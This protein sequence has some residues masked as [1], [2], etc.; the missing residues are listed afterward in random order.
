MMNNLL[1][2]GVEKL[3]SRRSSQPDPR[4]LGMDEVIPVP[5]DQQLLDQ[6]EAR[7]NGIVARQ[8]EG[9]VLLSVARL[10]AR[11]SAC[12]MRRTRIAPRRVNREPRIGRVEIQ[13]TN[14]HD[15]L[16]LR[17]CRGG[18]K[19]IGPGF[20][21][22]C[23][24]GNKPV[25]ICRAAFGAALKAINEGDDAAAVS[26]LRSADS[27][28]RRAIYDINDAALQYYL[29]E[30]E[31]FRNLYPINWANIVPAYGEI[32][33]VV[34]A[35]RSS[36]DT[37]TRTVEKREEAYDQIRP[38]ALALK[39]AYE[40]LQAHQTDAAQALANRN[41]QVLESQRLAAEAKRVSRRFWINMAVL[42]A[43]AACSTTS[44]ILFL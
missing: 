20:W 18:P 25:P 2:K 42:V 6:R 16:A 23:H 15:L 32:M 29:A 1:A 36:I 5:T 44:L 28:A 7:M 39:E 35:A 12:S 9:S 19:D 40:K 37:I 22:S 30:I 11:G 43:I 21:C 34:T 17:Y 10:D 13:R 3:F 27:H 31:S 38:H 8:A 41:S 14:R 33:A 4:P 26:N 24:S